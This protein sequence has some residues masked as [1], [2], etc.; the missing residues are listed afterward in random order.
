MPQN[1]QRGGELSSITDLCT[2]SLHLQCYAKGYSSSNV[3]AEDSSRRL[4]QDIRWMEREPPSL[5]TCEKIT[6]S[7]CE[8]E[9]SVTPLLKFGFRPRPEEFGLRKS[10]RLQLFSS[11][12][13]LP[14]TRPLAPLFPF[15]APRE[16]FVPPRLTPSS[17]LSGRK[18]LSS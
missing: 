5:V 13:V 17:S 8:L 2:A 14:M 1:K 15:L 18:P 11:P 3:V 6:L 4:N 10:K 12:L 7:D 9:F 16:G